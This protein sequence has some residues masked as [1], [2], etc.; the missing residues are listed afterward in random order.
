MSKILIFKMKRKDLP[1]ASYHDSSVNLVQQAVLKS[2][3][4]KLIVLTNEITD[5]LNDLYTEE[6]IIQKTI[7]DK[8]KK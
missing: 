2:F 7:K 5:A 1:K 6:C 3:K 8:E 4:N